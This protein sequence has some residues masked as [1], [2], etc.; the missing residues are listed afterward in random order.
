MQRCGRQRDRGV[1]PFTWRMTVTAGPGRWPG[2]GPG[3][4]RCT[5]GMP[6]RSTTTATNGWPAGRT[7]RTSPP[8]CS[9][10]RCGPANRCSPQ[11]DGGL[12]PW[13]LAVA[14]NL[15]RRHARA[16]AVA[17]RARG[18]LRLE[19]QE[20]PDIADS[21]ADAHADAYY[22][23]ILGEVLSALPVADRELI[24]LCVLQGIAP[25][26]GRR[27]H[28]QAPRHGPVPA[29]PGTRP[30]QAR[31]GAMTRGHSRPGPGRR[32]RPSASRRIPSTW[33]EA[34]DMDDLD[35]LFSRI[36][37]LELPPGTR[38]GASRPHHPGHRR[39]PTA[40]SDGRPGCR[41]CRRGA[42]TPPPPRRRCGAD[43]P[44]PPC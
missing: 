26:C 19:R 43:T 37:Q 4:P 24:Q 3:W 22:L 15:L 6:P 28:R 39:C 38:E 20:V 30:G 8:R 2:T 7:P 12:R 5:T 10:S 16:R 29:V 23:A 25:G 35:I 32:R 34:S 36:E 21:V 27:H 40:T 13:L 42:H 33:K 17:G 31:G 9:S 44:P 1:W 11:P 18:R 41:C 14:N